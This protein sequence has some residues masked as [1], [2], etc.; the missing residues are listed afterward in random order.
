[1]HLNLHNA[2]TL[3]LDPA[4]PLTGLIRRN[5]D[6]L[7]RTDSGSGPGLVLANLAHSD[8]GA[9]FGVV[10]GARYRFAWLTCQ[11]AAAI[12]MLHRDQ[13]VAV[14]LPGDPV[15][16]LFDPSSKKTGRGYLMFLYALTLALSRR[17]TLL[18]HGAA[19][20]PPG[21]ERAVLLM[22]RRGSCK[23]CVGLSLLNAGW[24]Y[25]G[26]DKLLL[27]ASGVH[28]LE[29]DISVRDWH[30][31]KL[32]WLRARLPAAA[33]RLD[34]R[35]Y[36]AACAVARSLGT[37]FL[38]EAL[39]ADWEARWN[40]GMR[41][42][43]RD[44]FPDAPIVCSAPVG[45]ALCLHPSPQVSLQQFSAVEALP[46]LAAVAEAMFAE[47]EPL[48]GLF[49]E[50]FGMASAPQPYLEVL[51]QSL[52]EVAFHTLGLPANTAF[53]GIQDNIV[54]MVSQAGKIAVQ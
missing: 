12:A 39:T 42:H 2:I 46:R 9:V 14:L 44:M 30:L 37:R 25:V 47:L 13:P 7:I 45:T 11:G 10:R 32:P 19:F 33:R 29:Q 5:L 51:R 22:G 34:T 54:E 6:A 24:G 1:M 53:D 16:L 49:Q 38:P 20:V 41:V 43:I 28:A 35:L 52:R 15:K 50:R 27:N 3:D 17:D 31:R 26:D 21:S 23:T 40:T 8:V 36:W 48:P 4:S 18:L